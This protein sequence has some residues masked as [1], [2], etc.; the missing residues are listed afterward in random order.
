MGQGITILLAAAIP[1]LT[2][3][4]LSV[5]T[6]HHRVAVWGPLGLVV[7]GLTAVAIAYVYAPAGRQMPLWMGLSA[8]LGGAAVAWWSIPRLRG[9]V[10]VRVTVGAALGLGYAALFGMT[11]VPMLAFSVPIVAIILAIVF[12]RSRPKTTQIA[13]RE[14]AEMPTPF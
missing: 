6:R 8:A 14:Q 4:A 3:I 10:S 11:V 9:A 13:L 2:A 5:P 7:L 1:L 12:A